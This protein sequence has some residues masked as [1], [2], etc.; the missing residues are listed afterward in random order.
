MA[1]N[2]AHQTR[3]KKIPSAVAEV[4]A[5][6]DVDVALYNEF[7]EGPDRTVFREQLAAA[8]YSHVAVSVTHGRHNQIMVASRRPLSLGCLQA[9]DLTP[10]AVSGFLHVVIEGTPIELV[11][12]RMPSYRG[13]KKLAYRQQLATIIE[14]ASDRVIALAGDINDNPFKRAGTPAASSL[15]YDLAESFTVTNP[16][17]EWSFMRPNGKGTSRVDHVLHSRSAQLEDVRYVT[18]VGGHHLAGLAENNP[19][20]DHA[21]LFFTISAAQR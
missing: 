10:P 13:A 16:V 2:L 3:R 17:G 8:G 9:P 19:I 5:L 7:V 12:V 15:P 18:E 4:T 20:S 14:P 6:L 21:A 1:W 11:G